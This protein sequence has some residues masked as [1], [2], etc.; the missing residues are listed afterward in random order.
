MEIFYS[1]TKLLKFIGLGLLGVGASVFVYIAYPNIF[2]LIIGTIG[3]IF[4]GGGIIVAFSRFFNNEP[5]VII[6]LNGIE[7]R[8]LN[9]GLINWNEIKYVSLNQTKY[10]QWLNLVLENP[11]I[12]IQQLS[13]IQKFLRKANGQTDFDGFRIRFIDLDT[14]I[15]DAGDYFEKN[16]LEQNQSLHLNP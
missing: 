8:R 3:L 5:Q 1:K 11:E 4:F 12:Y 7:D 15:D 9:L 6:N 13:K 2:G 14:P 10:A 16:V